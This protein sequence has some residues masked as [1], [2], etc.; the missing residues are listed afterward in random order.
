MNKKVIAFALATSMALSMTGCKKEGEL[1]KSELNTLVTQLT[2]QSMNKDTMIKN[3]KEI[4]ANYNPN[5]SN[6]QDLDE[7]FSLA[8]GEGA[9]LAFDD[10]INVT[11]PITITPSK[12]VQNETLLKL[13]NSVTFT[14]NQNWITRASSGHMELS[15]SSGVYGEVD[16][17]EYLGQTY[18]SQVYDEFLKPHFDAI[19]AEPVGNP[20]NIFLANGDHAGKQATVRLKVAKLKDGTLHIQEEEM[21]Q[22]YTESAILEEESTTAVET[23][24]APVESASASEESTSASEETSSASTEGGAL[25]GEVVT[26]D[27]EET[28]EIENYLYTVALAMYSSDESTTQVVVFKF[29]YPESNDAAENATKAEFVGSTIKSFSINGNPLTLQ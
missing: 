28:L 6:V 10:K 29:F 11:N 7:Y 16:C 9:Y 27:E 14:P 3:L 23:T 13:T 12:L 5:D 24:A 20:S 22:P 8:A 26:Q 25:T 18:A 19:K 21:T 2:E 1:S 4:I 17:Y 15:H